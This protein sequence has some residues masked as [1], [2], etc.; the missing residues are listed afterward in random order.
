[1]RAAVWHGRGDVR[2]EDVKELPA[3]PPGQVQVRVAWCGICGTDLH[4]YLGG[5]LYIPVDRPHPMTGVLAPVVIGHEVSGEIVA[6]GNDVERFAVGDRIAACPIIG[7]G[8]CRWCAS[9]SM[10]QCD[11]VAFLGT[12]W[13]SGALAEHVNLNAYQ[14]YH[15][16]PAISDEMGALVEPFSSAVRAVAQANPGAEDR[17]AVVG[18]GPIGLMA[19]V[20]ARLRGVRQVV[21][22]EIAERRIEA[23]KRCGADEVINPRLEDTEKRAREITEGQGF[24]LVIECCGQ[25]ATVLLA[26]RLTRT[27]GHLV[28]MGVFEK[29]APMDL[30]DLVFREKIVSGSMSGYGLYD[31]TIRLMTDPQFPGDLLITDRI[32]LEDLVGIGYYGLLHHKD[33]HIKILVRPA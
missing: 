11:Q 26:G 33:E 15:L 7:C 9:G 20:A 1:M 18:A 32:G 6:V 16:L 24:D 27:R 13:T 14:C 12:S 8:A 30:T 5:P 25:P 17:V 4:E 23:A 28:V 3:P 19:L 10:A 22:I 31:E 21:A 2:I 29:P